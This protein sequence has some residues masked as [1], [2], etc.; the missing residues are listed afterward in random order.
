MKIALL[1]SVVTQINYYGSVT[2]EALVFYVGKILG[3]FMFPIQ[4][5]SYPKHFISHPS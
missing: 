3:R 2:L 5:I 4:V 1:K